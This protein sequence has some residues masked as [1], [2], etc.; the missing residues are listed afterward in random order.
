MLR[1]QKALDSCQCTPY[2][3]A[4]H[5]LSLDFKRCTSKWNIGIVLKL[6]LGSSTVA[7]L[8]KKSD[9]NPLKDAKQN[10][11]IF[12]TFKEDSHVST[13]KR[14]SVGSHLLQCLSKYLCFYVLFFM[15]VFVTKTKGNK[16]ISLAPLMTNCIVRFMQT[17]RETETTFIQVV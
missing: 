14:E 2:T 13:S 1:F 7:I 3:K 11:A 15:L 17:S 16:K 6:C 9:R 12:I 4:L 5:L 10:F 8:R